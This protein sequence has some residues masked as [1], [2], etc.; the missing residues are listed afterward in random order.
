MRANIYVLV[1]KN[2]K[3]EE[4]L[5]IQTPLEKIPANKIYSSLETSEKLWA[6]TNTVKL[7]ELINNMAGTGKE[8]VI[9]GL[10]LKGNHEIGMSSENIEKVK[11]PTLIQTE[12]LGVFKRDKLVGWF[13]E[14]Q[15]VGFSDIVGNTKSTAS[16]ISYPNGGNISMNVIRS[17]SSMKAHIEDGKPKIKV[18]L[19]IEGNLGSVQS[20]IDLTKTETITELEKL[21]EKHIKSKMNSAVLK[22]QKDFKSDVFGFGE[23]IHRRHPKEWKKLEKNWDEEFSKLKVETEVVVNL[24]GMGTITNPIRKE[25]EE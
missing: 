7:D 15:S 17:K 10:V 25:I 6:S 9:T 22:A 14:M 13:D 4:I 8:A 2:A 3:A 11:T 1:A 21:F 12:N 16:T 24:R 20:N 23:E 5:D 18:L 19:K